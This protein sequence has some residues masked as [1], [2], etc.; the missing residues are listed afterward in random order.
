MEFL[1]GTMKKVLD[2]G[3]GSKESKKQNHL[4]AFLHLKEN[5]FVDMGGDP[6]QWGCE[7]D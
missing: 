7:L 2:E 4:Q 1:C 5:R 6:R 3:Q